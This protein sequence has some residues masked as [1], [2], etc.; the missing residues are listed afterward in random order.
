MLFSVLL[1]TNCATVQ[2]CKRATVQTGQHYNMLSNM[3]SR[4]DKQVD[5]MVQQLDSIDKRLTS[6]NNALATK[7]DNITTQNHKLADT[8]HNIDVG[9][10][11]FATIG[12]VCYVVSK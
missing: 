10:W 3:S 7:L 2:T 6:I 11:V 1:A 12:A 8:I 4:A 5:Q 9:L